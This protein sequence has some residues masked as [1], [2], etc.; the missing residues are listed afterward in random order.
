M[1]SVAFLFDASA[2][3]E[4]F[5]P[6]P[7]PGFVAWLGVLPRSEQLTCTLVLGELYAGAHGSSA[8]QK[9]IRRIEELVVPRLTVLPFDAGCARTYGRIRAALRTAGTPIGDAD[10]VIAATALTHGL[11]VVTANVRHFERVEGL[12]VRSVRA[13]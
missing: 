9:W 12:T 3:S 5:R 7:D 4:V 8:P 1:T 10:T 13:G 6:R 2:I 11:A